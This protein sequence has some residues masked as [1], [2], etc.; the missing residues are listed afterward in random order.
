MSW[1]VTF[2]ADQGAVPMV[3]FSTVL[4]DINFR[5]ISYLLGYLGSDPVAEINGALS[6]QFH[7]ALDVPVFNFQQKSSVQHRNCWFSIAAV[8]V[9]CQ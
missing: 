1:A 9:V 5:L 7:Q 4:M 2:E 8:R 6:N 3:Q